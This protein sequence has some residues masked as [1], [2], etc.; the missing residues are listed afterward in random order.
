[1]IDA[2]RIKLRERIREDKSGTYGVS[3]R[4]S[5]GRYPKARYR[6]SISFGSDPDRVEELQ[7]EIFVQI[8]SLLNF[9]LDQDYIDKVKETSLR[10][11]ETNLRENRYWL[12]Q[13]EFAYFHNLDPAQIILDYPQMI[14]N[15]TRE[16]IHEAAKKYFNTK[17]YVDVVLYPEN[18]SNNKKE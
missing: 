3:I 17:N 4:G 12:N 18:W 10:S 8:D 14:K 9:G 15:L 11:Y 1:M 5:F 6:I 13:I 16:D 2:L 7:K